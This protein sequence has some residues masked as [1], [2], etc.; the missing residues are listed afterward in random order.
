[1]FVLTTLLWLAAAQP[2]PGAAPQPDP[3][4]RKINAAT[5]LWAA[6]AEGT[7]ARLAVSSVPTERLADETFRL[8]SDVESVLAA[9]MKAAGV[10]FAHFDEIRQAFRTRIPENI[11]GARALLKLPRPQ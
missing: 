8:C 6:C 11:G 2:A 3:R 1:M 5:A 7:S 9:E 10:P 4:Y